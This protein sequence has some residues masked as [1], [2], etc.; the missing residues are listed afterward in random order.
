MVQKVQKMLSCDR[1]PLAIYREVV[2]HIRQIGNIE[3]SLL[4]QTSKQFEYLQ[5]QVGGLLVEYD[6]DFPTEKLRQLDSILAYYANKY[7][8]WSNIV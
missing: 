7:G 8:S 3:V 2:A 1:L 5:S 6:E 4:E